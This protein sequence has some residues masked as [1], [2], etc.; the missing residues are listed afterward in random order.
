MCCT[1]DAVRQSLSQMRLRGRVFQGALLN[2]QHDNRYAGARNRYYFLMYT[3][4]MLEWR[5]LTHKKGVLD[6][7]AIDSAIIYHC[8]ERRRQV[9][10]NH[11]TQFNIVRCFRAKRGMSYEWAL[12]RRDSV[13]MKFHSRTRDCRSVALQERTWSLT[14]PEEAEI[15]TTKEPKREREGNQVLQD[16][17]KNNEILECDL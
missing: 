15:E 1:L 3:P 9:N 2:A 6:E 16:G 5:T 12:F 7:S 14:S 8:R 17:H 11:D 13:M 4:V 10:H